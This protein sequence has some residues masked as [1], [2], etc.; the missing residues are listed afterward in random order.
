MNQICY[1]EILIP[2]TRH[3]EL[4]VYNCEHASMLWNATHLS[5]STKKLIFE[6]Y[7]GKSHLSF[8]LS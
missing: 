7:G 4:Y 8:F 5:G 3:C 2:G 6:C 1:R